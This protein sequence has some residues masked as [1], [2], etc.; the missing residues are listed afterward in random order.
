MGTTASGLRYPEP[1]DPVNQGATNMKNLATDLDPRP[2]GMLGRST[3]SGSVDATT[4]SNLL[5]TT[6]TLPT[7]RWIR[8]WAS[9]TGQQITGASTNL[10]LTIYGNGAAGLRFGVGTVA[11]NDT[12]VRLGWHEYRPA[13]GSFTAYVFASTAGGGA[14]RVSTAST[15]TIEDLG[16]QF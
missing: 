11:V 6:I 16:Y 13:A 14:F 3:L 9:I 7:Q 1:T 15:L 12:I 8:V 5:T 4:G 2:A 10:N